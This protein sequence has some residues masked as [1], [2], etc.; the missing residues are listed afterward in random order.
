[1]K[2]LRSLALITLLASF[3]AADAIIPT[4]ATRPT[5]KPAAPEPPPGAIRIACVGDSITYGHNIPDRE[6]QSYPARLGV[7]LGDKYFVRNYGSNGTTALK[8]GNRPYVQRPLYQAALAYKP[9]I[10][11]IGLG[12]NDTKPGN[13]KH[14]DEFVA[15]YES[16][17]TAFKTANPA[18]KVF[19]CVPVPD[20]MPGEAE[21]RDS[22]LVAEVNPMIKRIAKDTGATVIDLR[23]PL[24]GRKELFPDTIHPNA[25]GA[26]MMAKTVAAAIAGR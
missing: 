11:V 13:W 8:A 3:A 5:S 2:L 14:Q 1:M 9:D 22:V 17:I 16:I 20:F 26:A 25:E 21:I 19:V 10:V 7:Q 23:T 6:H 12:T 4:P 24:E 15:D 18:V